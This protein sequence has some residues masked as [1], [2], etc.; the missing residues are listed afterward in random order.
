MPYARIEFLPSEEDP[1]THKR[2]SLHGNVAAS[3]GHLPHAVGHRTHR[4]HEIDHE[5]RRVPAA[6]RVTG[7]RCVAGEFE[8]KDSH[9]RGRRCLQDLPPDTV[10][11]YAR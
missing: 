3:S 8:G 11:I 7:V 2:L 4:G 10:S 5:P 6:D 9:L 1:E